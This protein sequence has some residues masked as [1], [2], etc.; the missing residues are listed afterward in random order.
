[1]QSRQDGWLEICVH[2]LGVLRQKYGG[3]AEEYPRQAR[4]DEPHAQEPW[5]ESRFVN[6]DA[7]RK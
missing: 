7:K 2:L 5:Q 6:E 4:Q 1:M 3:K